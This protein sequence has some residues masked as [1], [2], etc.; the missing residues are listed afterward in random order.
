MQ[1]SGTRMDR[2]AALAERTTARVQIADRTKWYVMAS[3]GMGLFLS[4]IDGSIVNVALPSLVEALNTQF[5]TVQ[6]VVLAYLLTLATVTLSMGR[7]GDML[8]KKPVYTTGFVIFTLGSVLCG[9]SPT[10]HILIA[11]RALQAVG[12]AMPTALGTAILTEIFPSEERGLALGVSGV[13]GA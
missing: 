6:W 1:P 10:I 4:T 8:G 2:G 13:L 11:I 9:L 5:A 7:L 3:V 12:A